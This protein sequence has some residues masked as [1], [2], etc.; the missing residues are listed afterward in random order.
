MKRL[1]IDVGG[2]LIAKKDQSGADTNF[3][4]VKWLPGALESVKELSK[5]FDLYILSF[6]GK[7]TEQETRDAL[8]SEVLPY[9]PESK[10]IFTRKREHKVLRMQE[11]SI[12]ILIDDTLEIIE[13]VTK[14]NLKG[15]HYGSEQY[16]TW[17]SCVISLVN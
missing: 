6:C 2:V 13:A 15:V 9:I 8:R 5:H 17:D 1:A 16:S 3:D 11:L 10:W 12:D 7:K 14:A 4:E